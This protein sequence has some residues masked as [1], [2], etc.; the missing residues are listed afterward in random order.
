M[1]EVQAAIK[2]GLRY[3]NIDG[4]HHKMWV[5]DQMIRILAGESYDAIITASKVGVD[6]AETYGWNIGIAP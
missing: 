1:N 6:G 3:G 4:G 5:I 2:L